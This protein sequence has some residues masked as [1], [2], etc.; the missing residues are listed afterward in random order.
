MPNTFLKNF[1]EWFQ[2]KPKLDNRNHK[3]PF[4][5][6]GQI[7][8]CH[9]GENIG[10]EISGKS[11]QL[12]RPV[13]IFKKLSRHT[14]FGHSNFYQNQNGFLVCLFYSPKN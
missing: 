10:T 9:L 13:I 2:L 3:T 7:W 6:Q 14:F 5:S 8:W 1:L 11:S 4:V 12:T